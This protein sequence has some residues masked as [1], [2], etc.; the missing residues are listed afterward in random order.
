VHLSSQCSP[1]P[2][3][4]LD[5]LRFAGPRGSGVLFALVRACCA[6]SAAREDL[7][8]E[9][10][11][12]ADRI[13]PMA[14]R[15]VDECHAPLCMGTDDADEAAISSKRSSCAVRELLGIAIPGI[16]SPPLLAQRGT[17]GLTGTPL[18]SS[19]A[20]ITELAS[21]C[22]GTYVTGASAHWRTVERAS[23]SDLFLRYHDSVATR[24]Y[25]TEMVRA[26]QEFVR[27]AARRNV[28]EDDIVC[29]TR[30]WSVKLKAN[31]PFERRVDALAQS[32]DVRVA[33]YAMARSIAKK[34]E[35]RE[36][37]TASVSTPEARRLVTRRGS[38]SGAAG[39]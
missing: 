24:L 14:V 8:G 16:N 22:A 31:S 12:C 1:A 5:L 35:F 25:Q 37:L 23:S 30:E 6:A 15:H 9:R 19:V 21:L 13:L 38:S 10:Q 4:F 34:K 36:T 20:R 39:G 28:V 17:F 27:R 26:A 18:L 11:G 32:K 29:N 7:Q 3:A 2:S 33:G